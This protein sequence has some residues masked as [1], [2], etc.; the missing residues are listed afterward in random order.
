MYNKYVP[1]SLV[2]LV[3]KRSGYEIRLDF[4]TWSSATSIKGSIK[5]RFSEQHTNLSVYFW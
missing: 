1:K 2:G 3:N 5:N 4:L